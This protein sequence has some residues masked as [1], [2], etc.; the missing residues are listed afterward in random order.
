MV[1]FR[2]CIFYGMLIYISHIGVCVGNL[3][4]IL[5]FL[6]FWDNFNRDTYKEAK[7]HTF[8]WTNMGR[9]IGYKYIL[10]SNM[11]DPFIF[12]NPGKIAP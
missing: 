2:L 10:Q 1:L 5:H 12:L 11:G 8:W 6:V 3:Y 7:T 4:S 9:C